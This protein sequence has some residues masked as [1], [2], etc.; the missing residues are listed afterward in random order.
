MAESSKLDANESGVPPDPDSPP[1]R[2]TFSRP[3]VAAFALLCLLT[4]FPNVMLWLTLDHMQKQRN[5]EQLFWL[6]CHPGY[7]NEHRSRA[8][9]ELLWQGNREWR[10]AHLARLDLRGAHLAGASITQA[11]MEGCK[12]SGA[13]LAGAELQQTQLDQADLAGADLSDANLLEC[14]LIKADLRGAVFDGAD[15]RGA[16]LGQTNAADARFVS[17]NM[18]ATGLA[19]AVLTN[20]DLRLANLA[21]A[22]LSLADLT[23]ANLF[24]ANLTDADLS[25]AIMSDS[26]WW[27]ATGLKP[28]QIEQLRQRHPPS[29][30]ADKALRQDFQKWL[31]EQESASPPPEGNAVKHSSRVRAR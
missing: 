17:A 14:D 24:R 25:H 22:D 18:A 27:R 12:L 31:A 20:A 7:T 21:E 16:A 10:S 6:L 30:N 19:L 29:Q 11:H 23:S 4:T 2:V 15:L 13:D 8:F 1:C 5:K 26:N 3:V 28:Q 9:A